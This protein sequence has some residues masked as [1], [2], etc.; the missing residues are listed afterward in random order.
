MVS[1]PWECKSIIDPSDFLQR[2]GPLISL[3][4][5]IMEST[6]R[7]I[8]NLLERFHASFFFYLLPHPGWFHKIGSYLP[9]AIL[10]GAGMTIEGLQMWIESGWIRNTVVERGSRSWIRRGRKID[11]AVRISG[12]AFL[13]GLTRLK[14][15]K[16]VL[17]ASGV[18]ALRRRLGRHGHGII[19]EDVDFLSSSDHSYSPWSICHPWLC[20]CR[21][22]Q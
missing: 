18:S 12:V 10:I 2:V 1:M 7:A 8:N 6:L 15:Q 13:A 17:R 20:L 11:V 9:A 21:P 22:F 3:I 5:S 14:A 16:D 4:G 19:L